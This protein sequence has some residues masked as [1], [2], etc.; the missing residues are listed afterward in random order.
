VSEEHDRSAGAP[1]SAAA[2]EQQLRA[3]GPVG[4]FAARHRKKLAVVLPILA[5]AGLLRFG[6][7]SLIEQAKESDIDCSNT[8]YDEEPGASAECAGSARWWLLLPQISPWHRGAAVE[9]DLDI[10]R[11]VAKRAI[12][13]SVKVNPDC[14]ARDAAIRELAPERAF[15][16]A[17]VN[18]ARDEAAK[19]AEHASKDF[20]LRMAL[21]ASIGRGDVERA[22]ELAL[23]GTDDEHAYEYHLRRGAL[24]CLVGKEEEGRGALEQAKVVYKEQVH[25][26][27][28]EA[29]RALI[30][31]G[32]EPGSQRNEIYSASLLEAELVV[33]P[34][35][36]SAGRLERGGSAPFAHWLTTSDRTV[37][38]VLKRAPRLQLSLD[39]ALTQWMVSRSG[40]GDPAV[41]EA[42]A[43]RLGELH[44]RML[45][46]ERESEE[47]P[48]AI[49]KAPVGSGPE[50][51]AFGKKFLETDGR[52]EV[53]LEARARPRATLLIAEMVMLFAAMNAHLAMY[54]DDAACGVIDR[55]LKL[56]DNSGD[57]LPEGIEIFFAAVH[58]RAG[59]LDR[60]RELL[61]T[62]PDRK[63]PKVALFAYLNLAFLEL[64]VGNTEAA[65]DALLRTRKPS[66]EAASAVRLNPLRAEQVRMYQ[67]VAAW[68]L[69]V[70]SHRLDRMDDAP[71]IAT[72]DVFEGE[73]TDWASLIRAAPASR[74]ETRFGMQSVSLLGAAGLALP[75]F[76]YVMLEAASDGPD[77]TAF[78]DF[79]MPIH[80]D[81]LNGIT[82]MRARAE[83]HRWRGEK[84]KAATWDE[85]AA[86]LE[87]LA[88]DPKKAALM[89][90]AGLDG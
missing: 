40:V 10:K 3:K 76:I 57:L 13:R 42:A 38:Q 84:E 24:L 75:A 21:A 26:D 90:L 2:F 30:L 66:S 85:R 51:D 55:L 73:A 68:P 81:R 41:Y 86:R 78:L 18:G 53:P 63:E 31:C 16:L 88:T 14:A 39:W 35:G 59:K 69:I 61:Q 28:A 32:A 25:Y 1:D 15:V 8:D 46:S 49:G 7:E 50:A 77:A 19:L 56:D 47:Q 20:E 89:R 67:Y 48:P 37:A 87:A 71:K 29:Q 72:P 43:T 82:G 34:E 6:S 9:A 5:V 64:A 54:D 79:Q 12:I 22:A 74:R 52:Y 65:H 17:A 4:R 45:R 83:A 60:A 62:M 44:E 33:N 23:R 36:V 58:S 27:Y 80:S 70:T 11:N